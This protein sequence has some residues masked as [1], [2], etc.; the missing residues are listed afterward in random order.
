MKVYS[1]KK[2]TNSDY[3]RTAFLG[4]Q[5]NSDMEWKFA[6]TSLRIKY[7]C[8][9]GNLPPPFNIIIVSQLVH[10][11]WRKYRNSNGK[12]NEQQDKKQQKE[13]VVRLHQKI[14]IY[15]TI[16]W[17]CTYT[18]CYTYVY[19]TYSTLL[20]RTRNSRRNIR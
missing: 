14:L 10:Y 6:L 18:L 8:E 19:I 11:I 13:D 3:Q 15:L 16:T 5:V 2:L 12:K 1:K 17:H 9:V 4:S 7:Q 20:N